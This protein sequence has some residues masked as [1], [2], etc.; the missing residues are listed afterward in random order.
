MGN[1]ET[2]SQDINLIHYLMC[3]VSTCALWKSNT[4]WLEYIS[5]QFAN[6]QKNFFSSHTFVFSYPLNVKRTASLSVFRL[7]GGFL[8]FF[9]A[10]Q[11]KLT[12]TTKQNKWIAGFCDFVDKNDASKWQT[13]QN[14][15]L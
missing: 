15:W 9:T 2:K 10:G 5:D 13:E 11:T 12:K 8:F 7:L 1:V 4:K 6:W 3:L 14:I